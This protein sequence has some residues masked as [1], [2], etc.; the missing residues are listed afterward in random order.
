LGLV[1]ERAIIHAGVEIDL[2]TTILPQETEKNDPECR[3]GD[4]RPRTVGAAASGADG[5]VPLRNIKKLRVLPYG[6]DVA[7]L[8]GL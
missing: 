7:E 8:G 5:A 6:D 4:A 1:V 3:V 2:H